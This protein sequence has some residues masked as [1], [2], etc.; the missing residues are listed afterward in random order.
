MPQQLENFYTRP[1]RGRKS[2]NVSSAE[3]RQTMTDKER[4]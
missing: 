2:R 1:A 3:D 4:S